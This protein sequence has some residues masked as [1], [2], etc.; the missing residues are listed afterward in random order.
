MEV[1]KVKYFVN[2]AFLNNSK[3]IFDPITPIE[4]TPIQRELLNYNNEKIDGVMQLANHIAM[5][6]LNSEIPVELMLENIKQEVSNLTPKDMCLL[7]AYIAYP[8]GVESKLEQILKKIPSLYSFILDDSSSTPIEEVIQNFEFIS[9]IFRKSLSPCLKDGW[10]MVDIVFCK[11]LQLEQSSIL[12]QIAMFLEVYFANSA[13]M[14]ESTN[15][16]VSAIKVTQASTGGLAKAEKYREK[17]TP[18]F[19][20]VFVLFQCRKWKSKSEC[21]KY[22]IKEFYLKNPETEI[23]LDPKKLVTE[24]TNRVNDRSASIESTFLAHR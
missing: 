10:L 5:N 7:I 4:I 21:A 8:V 2:L 17:M 18:I 9:S 11:I 23:D 12:R 24:I 19:D 13:I 14:T 15:S 16:L 20:E 1:T 6:E 22:F 3:S